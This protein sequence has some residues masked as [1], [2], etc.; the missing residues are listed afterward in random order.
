MNVYVRRPLS[1][2]RLG[3]SSKM[4]VRY[5]SYTGYIQHTSKPN[6]PRDVRSAVAGYGVGQGSEFGAGVGHG[7]GAGVVGIGVIGA[8]VAGDGVG[9]GEMGP[10]VGCGVGFYAGLLLGAWLGTGVGCGV[11]FCVGVLLAT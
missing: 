2:R 5:E 10:I 8:E 11:G 7:V 9:P 6:T 1:S 4:K 3:G